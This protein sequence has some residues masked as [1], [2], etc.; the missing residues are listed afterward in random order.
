MNNADNFAH[1]LSYFF[2]KA[3]AQKSLDLREG[4]TANTEIQETLQ[5]HGRYMGKMPLSQNF[6]HSQLNC[7]TTLDKSHHSLIY[8]LNNYVLDTN[9]AKHSF[10][11]FLTY[12]ME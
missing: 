12:K 1:K 5:T 9:V 7:C 8:L 4:F 6:P 2:L 11:S 10:L 3:W